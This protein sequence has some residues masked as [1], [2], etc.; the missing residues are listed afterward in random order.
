MSL[1]KLLGI[2]TTVATPKPDYG[3]DPEAA[4]WVAPPDAHSEAAL[5]TAL[6]QRELAQRARVVETRAAL[7]AWLATQANAQ[8]QNIA[9]SQ[10]AAQ[11]QWNMMQAPYPV[12]SVTGRMQAPTSTTLMSGNLARYK[13]EGALQRLAS[14]IPMRLAAAIADVRLEQDDATGHVYYEVQTQG[15]TV[16]TFEDA[17]AFP[18]D[19]DIARIAIEAK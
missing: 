4:F 2:P 15:G 3:I 14:A 13:A 18:T 16:L 6:A 10:A 12:G 9:Q 7:D 1:K 11:A 19:A 17:D 8:A 5:A